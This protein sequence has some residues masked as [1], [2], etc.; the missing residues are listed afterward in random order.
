[1]GGRWS[2]KERWEVDHTYLL[3]TMGQTVCQRSATWPKSKLKSKQVSGSSNVWTFESR[4]TSI[5]L[6]SLRPK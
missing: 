4:F 3:D 6:N 5:P 2:R 1:V